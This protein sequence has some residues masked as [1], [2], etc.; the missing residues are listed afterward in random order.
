MAD[1]VEDEDGNTG[2]DDRRKGKGK[3]YVAPASQDEFDRI[4]DSRLK[5]ERSKFSDYESLKAKAEQWDVLESESRTD[6]ERRER[7]LREEAFMEAMSKAVPVAVRQAFRAE[8]KGVLS[9]EQVE[10]LLEDLDLTR[11]AN[12]DGEPD[13]D[14]I[15]KKVAAFAPAKGGGNGRGPGF[16]QGNGHQQS[17]KSRGEGGL[18]EAKRRFPEQFATQK[19]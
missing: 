18:I 12:D 5:Q 1:P 4:V 8:A 15:A 11:Y 2:G 3:V 13:E 7:E 10:S 17:T 6:T 9:K 19:S 14:K 16:G